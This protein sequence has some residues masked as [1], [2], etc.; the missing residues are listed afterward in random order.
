MQTDVAGCD[1]AGL[2]QIIRQLFQT[3]GFRL[4]KKGAL[5]M[6]DNSDIVLRTC[7]PYGLFLLFNLLMMVWLDAF[8]D[9][10]DRMGQRQV[11]SV[12][13]LR[14]HLML[15][16]SVGIDNEK[17]QNY[18][19]VLDEKSQR[20]KQLTDDLVEASKITS[21][22]SCPLAMV[23]MPLMICCCSFAF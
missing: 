4:L 23:S 1:L 7:V 22:N 14:L 8:A 17:V 20:L 11:I 3:L 13:L 21:G 6:Y 18:I 16:L 12:Q 15:Q 9:T 2:H 19:K 5:Q 10:V